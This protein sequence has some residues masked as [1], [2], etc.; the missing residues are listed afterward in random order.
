MNFSIPSG[1]A[2]TIFAMIALSSVQR[3]AA[4]TWT[5]I[6]GREIEAELINHDQNEVV[7]QLP[8]GKTATVPLRRFSEKDLAFLRGEGDEEP[9]TETEKE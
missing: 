6:T 8:N 3:I 2:A 7:L 5:D 4:R 9:T 1:I